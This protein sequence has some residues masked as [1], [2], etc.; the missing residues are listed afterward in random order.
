MNDELESSRY[1]AQ[2]LEIIA[3][4][5]RKCFVR[6]FDMEAGVI[7]LHDSAFTPVAEAGPIIPPE[8]TDEQKKREQEEL[9]FFSSGA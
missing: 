6:R 1:R 3:T 7:E 9:L 2:S 4:A 5:M 8:P